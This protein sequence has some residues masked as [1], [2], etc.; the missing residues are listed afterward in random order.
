MYYK[1]RNEG[2]Y[3]ND[4]RNSNNIIIFAF[5]YGMTRKTGAPLMIA[6]YIKANIDILTNQDVE[7][8]VSDID[9]YYHGDIDSEWFDLRNW[10]VNQSDAPIRCGRCKKPVGFS[11]TYGK[12]RTNNVTMM[13]CPTKGCEL[14]PDIPERTE[15]EV[16]KDEMK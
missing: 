13:Y 14:I 8:I 16:V 4:R 15:S 5:R 10:L 9:G 7:E 6:N 3:M 2:S 11:T 1:E 12:Q